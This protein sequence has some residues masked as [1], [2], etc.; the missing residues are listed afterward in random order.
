MLSNLIDQLCYKLYGD[1]EAEFR[2][3]PSKNQMFP[4]NPGNVVNRGVIETKP[5][6]WMLLEF[7]IHRAGVLCVSLGSAVQ[8]VSLRPA[9][10]HFSSCSHGETAFKE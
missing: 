2:A 5:K 6:A 7:P 1:I 8:A 9:A 4:Q 10:G 3:R